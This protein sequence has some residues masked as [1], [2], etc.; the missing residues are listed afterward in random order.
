MDTEIIVTIITSV[1]STLIG[2]GGLFAF[3]MWRGTIS[4]QRGKA[5]QEAD[6]QAS[7]EW[8]K[9]YDEMHQRANQQEQANRK[10]SDEVSALKLQVTQLS[11][12]IVNYKRYDHYVLELES[13]TTMVVQSLEPLVSAEAFENISARRPQRNFTVDG[14]HET[15]VDD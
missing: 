8:H 15:I 12:E 10:L 9:L 13:Y 2:S 1:V 4:I 11:L 7:Q 5:Q 6:A 3:L 14:I